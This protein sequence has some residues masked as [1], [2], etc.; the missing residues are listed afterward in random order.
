MS[1]QRPRVQWAWRPRLGLADLSV[2]PV[3][4]FP[5][6]CILRQL[7]VTAAQGGRGAALPQ[8]ACGARPT[9]GDWTMAP[10]PGQC[11]DGFRG[12]GQHMLQ[13]SPLCLS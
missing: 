9:G 12:A 3:R 7:P 2:L 1:A 8:A 10:V 13:G 5:Q 4:T 11:S 6:G